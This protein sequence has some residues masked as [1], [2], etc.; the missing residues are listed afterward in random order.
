MNVL[1][2]NPRKDGSIW[3]LPSGRAALTPQD[4]QGAPCNSLW[5]GLDQEVQTPVETLSRD[6]P[7]G[8]CVREEGY[9]QVPCRAV[10]RAEAAKTPS[11]QR[12]EP[13]GSIPKWGTRS[14]VL[15]LRVCP[16]QLKDPACCN[17]GQESC[18]QTNK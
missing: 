11:S 7:A 6:P 4:C 15:Q 8:K 13:G 16:P 17:E 14:H 9:E 3:K 10:L 5:W 1:P 2:P 18:V 12:R